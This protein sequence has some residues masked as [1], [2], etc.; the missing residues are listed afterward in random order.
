MIIVHLSVDSSS[1]RLQ[2]KA[3]YTHTHTRT[4]SDTLAC[5]HTHIHI[6]LGVSLCVVVICHFHRCNY[7]PFYLYN[8]LMLN[9]Q[10]GCVISF[11]TSYLNTDEHYIIII[12]IIISRETNSIV[13]LHLYFEHLNTGTVCN[14][15]TVLFLLFYEDN[16]HT[17]ISSYQSIIGIGFL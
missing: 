2:N 3:C 12:R 5:R 8:Y 17:F 7:L 6:K 4:R 9:R 10:H 15:R 13:L 16:S 1:L 14:C 11:N